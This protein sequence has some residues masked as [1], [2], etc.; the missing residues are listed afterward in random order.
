VVAT[1][2][3]RKP[4]RLLGISDDEVFTSKLALDAVESLERLAI[5]G[6]ADND[7]ST[8]KQVHVED[9]SRLAHLPEHVVGGIDGIADRTLVEYPQAMC[10]FVRRGF[11]LDV[12]NRAGAEARA[13]IGFCDHD[14]SRSCA[15]RFRQVRANGF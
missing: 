10:D 5:F 4:D 13:K 12:A 14:R 11:D 15:S 6:L 3:S 7:L 8:F 1:H 9:V 2:D